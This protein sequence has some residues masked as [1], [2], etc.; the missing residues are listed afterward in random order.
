MINVGNPHYVIASAQENF[1]MHEQSWQSL[2]AKIAADP[3]FPH[4]TNVEF[5]RLKSEEEIEVRIFERGVGP[6][7]SS[8][9]GTCA[10]AAAAMALHGAARSLTAVAEGGAQTVVW[11]DAMSEMLL[12][13]PAEIVC[14]GE[15]RLG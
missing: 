15:V 7:S 6:T 14:R 10:A 4:G 11:P 1:G 13:G 9:T 2:G 8:G 3:L 5:L 12:T